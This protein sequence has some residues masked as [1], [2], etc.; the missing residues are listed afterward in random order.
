MLRPTP[1]ATQAT[2]TAA[3]ACATFYHNN[4]RHS[5]NNSQREGEEARG[6]TGIVNMFDWQLEP[7]AEG[8]AACGA[9]HVGREGNVEESEGESGLLFQELLLRLLLLLLLFWFCY[10][11]AGCALQ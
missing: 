11:P 10:A 5:S 3:T 6:D 1:Q 4:K 2:A 8:D 7:R 9:A